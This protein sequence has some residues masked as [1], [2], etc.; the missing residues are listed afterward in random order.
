MSVRVGRSDK[1]P[2]FPSAARKAMGD[3]Q[4]RHNVRN[5]TDVIR[6]KRKR[7]VDEMPD[8]QQLRDSAHAI[9]EHTLAHLDDYL[10]EFEAACTGA[11]GQVHWARDADEANRI[12]V[13]LIQSHN[14]TEVIKVKTMTSDETQLNRALETAGITP[15]ETDLAD[16]IVQL[17][18]DEPSHI[19]VPA[20]HRNRMEI[21]RIFIERMGLA[22]LGDQPED[23]TN[24]ARKYLREKFLRVKIGISGANFAVAET[25]FGLR[26]RIGR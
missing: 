26:R 16:L 24:A 17:G 3:T 4:L 23:L 10:E 12:I 14:E 11:G 6:S 22:D 1:A 9:K 7:V 21:R 5:A 13:G 2:D 15:V 19:V 25:G 8:W 20:L 18:R